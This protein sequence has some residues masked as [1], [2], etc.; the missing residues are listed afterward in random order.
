MVER[1]LPGTFQKFNSNY[2][3]EDNEHP[4]M[5]AFSHWSYTETKGEFMVCDLQG[6]LTLGCI[7]QLID[8]FLQISTWGV[9]HLLPGTSSDEGYMLTDPAVHSSKHQFIHSCTD[10]GE[11]GMNAVLQGHQCT[12]LCRALGLQSVSATST[13]SGPAQT[14]YNF[15]NW[16]SFFALNIID[17]NQ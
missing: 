4:I 14:T 11:N 7:D 5:T 3:F 9:S 12:D 15:S 10:L 6:T 1:F 13:C 8:S 16:N 17:R 2:G